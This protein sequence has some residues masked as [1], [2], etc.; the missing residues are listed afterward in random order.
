MCVVCLRDD[1]SFRWPVSFPVIGRR[2]IVPVSVGLLDVGPRRSR[3]GV[4]SVFGMGLP[5]QTRKTITSAPELPEPT[6]TTEAACAIVFR[7][8]V[9]RFRNDD[10]AHRPAILRPPRKQFPPAQ[11]PQAVRVIAWVTAT[12]SRPLLECTDS[13]RDWLMKGSE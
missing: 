2:P 12:Q 7:G 3:P 6:C 13:P 11:P 10:P 4:A 8:W 1:A 5:L 9:R